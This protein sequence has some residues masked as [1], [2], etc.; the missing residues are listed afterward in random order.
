MADVRRYRLDDLRRF[1]AGLATASGLAPARATAWVT[2]L[3]WFDAAGLPAHG[4]ATLP[5]WLGR[6]EAGA[7][8]PRAEVV[9]GVERTG[10]AVADAR[11]GV[12]L[13]ALGR[14]AGVAAE[15]ARDAGVGLVRLR[16]V[17]APGPAAGVAA[18]AAAGGPVAVLMLGPGP[19]WAVALPGEEGL[20]A[21][22][23]PS[24]ATSPGFSAAPA[25][26]AAAEALAAL[27]GPWASVLAG[28]G[29]WLVAALSVPA[30][31]P[32]TTFHRR[33]TEAVRGL[34]PADGRLLPAPWEAH[35]REARERGVAV[36]THAWRELL[37]RAERAGLTPPAETPAPPTG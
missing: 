14:A 3:L 26:P 30:W 33:V 32:L 31:E 23:D 18:S 8:D 28:E 6:I 35:R 11:Q 22:F 13:L 25:T 24:L 9:I 1:A 19:C 34:G 5:A 27:I 4:L 20:P 21:V 16:N 17:V 36:E 29:E 2:Q 12:P 37:D 15:K 10:T 7:V